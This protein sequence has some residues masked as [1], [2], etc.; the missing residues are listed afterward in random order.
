MRLLMLAL[1]LLPLSAANLGGRAEYIGGTLD[2]KKSVSGRIA[3]SDAAAMRFVNKQNNVEVP[4]ARINLIEYGQKVDRR[5]LAAALI[6]PV[7][8]LAKSRRH[9]LTVGYED[10]QGRQQALVLRVDKNDIRALLASL[11]ART[12]IRVTFQDQEARKAGK[13]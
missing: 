9:F 7:L 4:Y 13:G 11:E 2:F 6:S 5:Y 1:S 12:G 3:T 8:I 10:P